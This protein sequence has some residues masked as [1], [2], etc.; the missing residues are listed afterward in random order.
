VT[1]T[2]D[3]GTVTIPDVELVRVGNWA[4]ALSGRVPITGDDLDAMVAAASDP[5]VDHAPL[6]IGHVDPRFDGEPALGWL[7]NVRRVGDSLV[8]DLTDVPAKL[9]ATIRSAFRR[10]SAEIAWGVKTPAGRTYRAA[11]SGLALLGVTPPAVKG[12]ADVTSRYSGAATATDHGEVVLIDDIVALSADSGN[13]PPASADDPSHVHQREA[14]VS[15]DQIR[16]LLGLAADA[17]VTDQM[18][19][20]ATRLADVPPAPPTPEPGTPP[21]PAPVP[22]APAPVPPVS[23]EPAPAPA[24]APEPAPAPA[25]APTVAVDRAA[26]EQLQAQ[27]AAGARAAAILDEQE[28]EREL[29]GALSGGRIAPASVVQWRAAWDRDKEGTRALLSTLPQVF[30]TV[31]NFSSAPTAGNAYADTGD[32]YTDEQWADFSKSLGLGKA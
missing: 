20:V 4:S 10:R 8:A 30:S 6:R 26:L 17:P 29:T 2:T 1:T 28:R 27:A 31:T 13:L 23:P 24:P 25:P 12:L 32:G 18:R 21:A 19:S 11:L 3:G 15:D 9:A 7:S 14:L 16:E 5:E 22:P